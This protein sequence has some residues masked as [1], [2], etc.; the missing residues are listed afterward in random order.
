MPLR[1]VSIRSC[2]LA[3]AVILTMTPLLAA[4]GC[5]P[6]VLEGVVLR[7]QAWQHAISPRLDLKLEAVPAGWMVRVLPHTG[8][9]P[10]HDAAELANPPYRSPTPILVST[11][12][13]FRAQDAVAW[14]PRT[15]RFFALPEQTAQAEAIYQATMKEPNRPAAGEALYPLLGAAPEGTLTILDAEIVGGT[16]NQA[17]AA[18]TVASHFDQT[19]HTVRTDVAGTPLGSL[20]KLR[21]RFTVPSLAAGC[22]R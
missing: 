2:L 8:G 12:F 5:K 18:A 14:N 19:A 13:A 16:A 15:F 3:T 11:D 1:F 10:P 6:Q 7:G 17:A 22:G 20:L 21:F 9:R 4:Q